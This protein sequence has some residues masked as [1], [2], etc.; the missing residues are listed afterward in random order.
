MNSQNVLYHKVSDDENYT[1]RYAVLPIVKYLDKNKIIWC[2]FDTE[3][4]EYVKV[5]KEKGFKVEYSCIQN[6]QDFF[7]Y[8]PKQ[9]DI[10]VS[11]PPYKNKRK[12]FERAL[13]FN[14]PFALLMT[15]VWLNDSTPKKLFTKKDLQLLMF[16]ER[17]HFIKPN[18]VINKKTTF[19]S[20][21]YC[22]NLLP[23]QIIMESLKKG[24]IL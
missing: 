1:P 7:L 8:E 9:W 10:I 5:L 3:N 23:K 20:S 16:E 13:A 2:P 4:S 14:K 24:E 11:N 15:N 21:Y 19:S 12:F 22:W 6:G 18:G 17:I